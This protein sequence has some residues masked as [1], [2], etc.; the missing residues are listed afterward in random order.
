MGTLSGKATDLDGEYHD[1][2]KD[3]VEYMEFQD[4]EHIADMEEANDSILDLHLVE[5]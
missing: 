3:M 1:F 5:R 2:G 4:S